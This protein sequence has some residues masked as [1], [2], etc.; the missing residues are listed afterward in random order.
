[1]T[2]HELVL[3]YASSSIYPSTNL[4]KRFASCSVTITSAILFD[5]LVVHVCSIGSIYIQFRSFPS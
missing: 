4:G 2:N 1:M 3:R 5:R